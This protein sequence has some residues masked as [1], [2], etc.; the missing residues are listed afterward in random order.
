MR[1]TLLL[2][3]FTLLVGCAAP[4][5]LHHQTKTGD[6]FYEDKSVCEV[7][8]SQVTTVDGDTVHIRNQRR[9]LE[10]MRGKG[11]RESGSD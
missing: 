1:Q 9:F 5:K 10:C 11:W 2:A 7:R 8:A 3:V 6:E 4:V